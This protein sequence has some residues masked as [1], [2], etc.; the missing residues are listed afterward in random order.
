MKIYTKLNE[1]RIKYDLNFSYGCWWLRSAYSDSD[2]YYSL[3]NYFGEVNIF[4][5][6]VNY[7]IAPTCMI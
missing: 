1:S 3:N 2:Y 5:I 7:G 4:N 6:P